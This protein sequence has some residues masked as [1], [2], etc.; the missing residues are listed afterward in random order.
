MNALKPVTAVHVV[1]GAGLILTR[2]QK[3]TNIRSANLG[4]SS[5]S[6]C[7]SHQGCHGGP[8]K[9]HRQPASR[10]KALSRRAGD[11]EQS[12]SPQQNRALLRRAPVLPFPSCLLT[13]SRVKHPF[14]SHLHFSHSFPATPSG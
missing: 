8:E 5:F 2:L 7:I 14:F 12:E 11:S 6:G 1:T 4:F 9:R 13:A 3:E 10:V